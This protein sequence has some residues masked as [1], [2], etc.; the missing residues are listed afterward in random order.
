[1]N[2]I[3]NKCAQVKRRL[4]ANQ[5]LT[6]ELLAFALDLMPDPRGDSKC[7]DLWAGIAGKLK[8]G[9]QLN[10]YEH[11]LMV[12]VVLLHVRLQAATAERLESEG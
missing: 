11:H 12:D 7:D 9:E 5:P 2:E 1:M 3:R 4:N 8:D 6:G 10:N